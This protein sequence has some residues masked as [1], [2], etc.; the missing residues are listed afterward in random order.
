MDLI[1]SYMDRPV[2]MDAVEYANAQIK[3]RQRVNNLVTEGEELAKAKDEDLSSLGFWER[4]KK[5]NET[6][7]LLKQFKKNVYV[8]EEDYDVLKLAKNFHSKFGV[9][10]Y[11]LKLS[12]GIISGIISLLWIIQTAIYTLPDDP[13]HPFLNTY[14][15]LLSFFPLFPV[16]TVLIISVYLLICV[17]VGNFKFGLR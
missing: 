16:V 15:E 12:L 4:R 7:A 3:I 9:L 13:L 17:I 11:P 2:H 6:S 1:R 14:L 8:L 10:F 5:S